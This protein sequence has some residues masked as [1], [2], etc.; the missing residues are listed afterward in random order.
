MS[1]IMRRRNGLIASSVM[2][3]LLSEVGW[4]IPHLQTG[5]SH[6]VT[7]LGRAARRSAL[8]RERFSPL[9]LLRPPATP[10]GGP[11][12][13]GNPD[14]EQRT[15]SGLASFLAFGTRSTK[16]ERQACPQPA[17]ADVRPPKRWSAY[18]PRAG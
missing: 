17:E 10:S 2:G 5:R 3:M 11:L 9:A 6:S 1:S 16:P 8:P 12:M 18:D 13:V 15:S 7:V 4:A 14:I